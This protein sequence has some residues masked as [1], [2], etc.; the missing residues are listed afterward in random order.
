MGGAGS[1][2]LG[3]TGHRVLPGGAA[4]GERVDGAI[5]ALADGRRVHLLTSLAEG[6]DR[7]VAH[8]VL[9]R[10]GGTIEAI[11]PLAVD[12]YEDDFADPPSRAEFRDLLDRAGATEVVTA[13]TRTAA[14]EAAGFAVVER[15]EALVAL[16]DGRPARGR[17]GTADVVAHARRLGHPVQVVEVDR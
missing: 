7:L 1:I 9:A 16:W 10:A 3:V 12:D 6:A 17:G 11:L 5:D 2:T 13:P 4:L 15:S 14:Y 8:R